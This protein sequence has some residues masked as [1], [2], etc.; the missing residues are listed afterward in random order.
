MRSK[1]IDHKA[2][3]LFINT[4]IRLRYERHQNVTLGSS[5]QVLAR[6]APTINSAATIYHGAECEQ[7][8]NIVI[9]EQ[10]DRLFLVRNKTAELNYTL[11]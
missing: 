2:L 9:Y 10:T 1:P 8:I 5:S 7:V 4:A 11:R 6:K 3:A